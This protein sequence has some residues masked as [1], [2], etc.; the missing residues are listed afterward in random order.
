MFYFNNTKEFEIEIQKY[1]RIFILK[2]YMEISHI[3]I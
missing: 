1:Y 2:N 3:K